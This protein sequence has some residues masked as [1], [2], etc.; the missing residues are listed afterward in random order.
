[1][2]D[3]DA[4]VFDMDG[5]LVHRSDADVFRRAAREAFAAFDVEPA[6]EHVEAF[7]WTRVDEFADACAPY[8]LDPEAVIAERE[9]RSAAI[10]R[11]VLAAGGKALYDD[12]DAL[13][14]LGDGAR[15][16]LVSNNQH[17]TV[18]AVVDAHG[19]GELFAT[20][21]GRDPTVAGVA[22]RKPDPHY[23]ERALADLG[24][25]NA[26]YVGDSRVDVAAAAAAGVDS[27]FVWRDHREGYDLEGEE[28]THE[29]E[30]LAALP[31]AS[32]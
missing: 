16:G 1:M 6:D 26:L 15:L 24:T 12:V 21:Y 31:G 28:P 10:Q 18:E 4:V 8:D 17:A 7:A 25:R 30:T 27:A 20:A 32:A 9:A 5:V 19:L 11:A 13:E 14:S 23:L 3:Y 29:V 22:R 2:T